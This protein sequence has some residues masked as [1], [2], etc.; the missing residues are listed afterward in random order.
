MTQKTKRLIVKYTCVLA[1]FILTLI[2]ILSL[3]SIEP[4]VDYLYNTI[5]K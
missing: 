3:L 1:D 5:I 2:V 4:L